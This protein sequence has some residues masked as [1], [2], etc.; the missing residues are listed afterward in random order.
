[1]TEAFMHT[2]SLWLIVGLVVLQLAVLYRFRGVLRKLSYWRQKA[3]KS[4][5]QLK[6]M[7]NGE[8]SANELSTSKKASS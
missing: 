3:M 1:M 6:N 4:N 2:V 5:A 7:M 8:S